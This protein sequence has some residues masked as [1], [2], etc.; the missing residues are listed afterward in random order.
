MTTTRPSAIGLALGLSI[1][2]AAAG[3]PMLDCFNDEY[4]LLTSEAVPESLRVTDADL[5]WMMRELERVPLATAEPTRP[6]PAIPTD[7]PLTSGHTEDYVAERALAGY[8]D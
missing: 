5:A 8:R 3:D 1:G 6:E 7:A 4:P 2:T